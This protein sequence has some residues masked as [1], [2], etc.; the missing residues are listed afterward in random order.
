VINELIL[1][2]QF[3]LGE[4][5]T[6][7]KELPMVAGV[8]SLWGLGVITYITRHIPTQIYAVLEKQFTVTLDLRSCDEIYIWFLNWYHKQGYSN[9]SRTLKAQN[10]YDDD[11]NETVLISAGY[12]DHYFWYN[13]RVFKLSREE[14]ENKDSYKVKEEITL[15]TIGRSQKSFRKLLEEIIPKKDEK[16]E[17]TEIYTWEFGEWSHSREQLPRPLDSVILP[18]LGGPG[19]NI[20]VLYGIPFSIYHSF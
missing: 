12:G 20:P 4:F 5:N 10:I 16:L 6:W 7:A 13:G 14:Q 2:A 9:K 11:D 3:Y 8:V 19:R 1:Q 17:L 15:S 18:V